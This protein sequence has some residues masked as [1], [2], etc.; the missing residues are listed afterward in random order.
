MFGNKFTIMIK[1]FLKIL[2]LATLFVACKSDA[3]P[4]YAPK[5]LT[6]MTQDQVLEMAKN[7]SFPTPAN[8]V[9]KDPKGVTLSLDSLGKIQEP[10]DYY[11]S[12][13]RDA[14]GTIKEV[15]IKKASDAEK[16][17]NEKVMKAFSEQ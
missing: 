10:N 12:Y 13:F 17:F 7:K 6:K 11:Q 15:V 4:S 14:S 2:V 1:T 5:G 9:Y 8:V 3:T 16:T